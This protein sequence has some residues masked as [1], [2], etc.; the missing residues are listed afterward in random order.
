MTSPNERS[1]NEDTWAPSPEL[2]AAYFDGEFEGRDE[3]APLRR[4]LED[5]LAAKESARAELANYR[6]L[7]RLWLETTPAD[8]GPAA[9]QDV[10]DR[11]ESCLAGSHSLPG[12]KSNRPPWRA[13]VLLAGAAA[14][15]VAAFVF[16][17][18]ANAPEDEGVF[19][20]ASES[21]VVILHVEG[22]DTGTLVVGELPLR[23]PLVLA[24]PGDV[25]LT[26]VQPAQRDNMVPEVHVDG[27]GRPI[28]WARAESEE[29]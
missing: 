17:N 6:R 19:P 24:G 20:V 21:E 14:V 10:Q 22:A 5:W 13:R 3:L 1:P 26:S 29:D 2:L 27:S 4:R 11:L 12:P 25:T 16:T 23:G 18:R 9:W 8:P 15:L 28:I 7:S